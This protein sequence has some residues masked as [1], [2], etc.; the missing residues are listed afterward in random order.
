MESPALEYGE[1]GGIHSLE[2]GG[3]GR[4]QRKDG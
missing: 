3:Q 2:K 1:A 4:Q